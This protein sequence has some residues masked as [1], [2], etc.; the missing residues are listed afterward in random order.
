MP[1]LLVSA[2]SGCLLGAG[3]AVILTKQHTLLIP[4]G[5]AH[6]LCAANLNWV[7]SNH[8]CLAQ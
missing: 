6:M 7:A 2:L 5:L 3:L 8:C 4:I 1:R